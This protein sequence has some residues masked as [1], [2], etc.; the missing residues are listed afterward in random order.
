MRARSL[1]QAA[2]E[3]EEDDD[4]DAAAAD[5]DDDSEVTDDANDGAAAGD[6]A[7]TAAAAPP[8]ARTVFW[9]R[10]LATSRGVE[11][12]APRQPPTVP[13]TKCCPSGPKNPIRPSTLRRTLFIPTWLGFLPRIP[14]RRPCPP[15]HFCL[16]VFGYR[17]L[18]VFRAP[19]CHDC[20]PSGLF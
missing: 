19:V 1:A 14:L 15:T 13:A 4:D 10:L 16:P 6:A 12:H 2:G 3:L 9:M 7:G 5:D 17:L 20:L 18:G 11:K 8:R